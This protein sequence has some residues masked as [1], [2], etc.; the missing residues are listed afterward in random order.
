MKRYT[1]YADRQEI[2]ELHKQGY[3]YRQI[4]RQTGWSY[5][6]VRLV[7]R[8]YKRRGEAALQPQ[9]VGRPATGP[10]STFDPRVRFAALRLKLKHSG[11]GPDIVG[12]ELTKQTWAHQVELPS[13]SSLG[14][15]FG[16]FGERLVVVRS[17]K[18]LPQA[19]PLPPALRVVHGCWQMDADERV[20]L[21]GFGLA[22]ILNIVDHVSGVKIGAFLFPAHR[23]GS[24]CRVSW[25]QM[26]AAL[27][28]AFTRWGLPGRIRTDRDRVIVSEGNYPFPKLFTLWLVGLGIE[29]ELI[30]RV[31]QNGC[32]ERSH[33]TW[34]GR[35][36][37]YGPFDTLADW[38]TIVDYERWRMNAIL[39]SRGRQC[40]RRPPL[41]VYPQACTPHRY[42]RFQDE[43]ALFDQ[44][45]IHHYL[46]QGKWLRHTSSKGQFSLNNQKF[47]VGTAYKRRWVLITFVP[48][49]GFQVSCPPEPRVL[50]TIEV[51]GLTVADITGLPAGV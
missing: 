23:H 48:E 19:Q 4:V 31:T 44:E 35:L 17:H 14:A 42:Y 11:W 28:Q 6:T 22:H 50:K 34:E 37:G 26:Q 51:A 32:V 21:P 8:E 27:R 30:R 43:P 12:A 39:P 45:R 18:Q 2:I 36:V 13:S 3:S 40:R 47:C 15:Y 41:M 25:P 1:S 10:L 38:Q 9:R 24:R 5:E 29:H 20:D 46:A 7:C 16:Q 33:R 49:L